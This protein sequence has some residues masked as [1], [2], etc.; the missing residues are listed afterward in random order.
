MQ[1]YH[2]CYSYHS[3]LEKQN[4]PIKKKE[5]T[6]KQMKQ[7]KKAIGKV[8]GRRNV[9]AKQNRNRYLYNYIAGVSENTSQIKDIS[10]FCAKHEVEF[11]HC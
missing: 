2:S 1:A 7:T 5:H 4:T 3:Y 6:T 11:F 10:Q 9:N 8:N